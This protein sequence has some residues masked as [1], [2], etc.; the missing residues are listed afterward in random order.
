MG[1]L[2]GA[3]VLAAGFVAGGMNAVVGAGTLVSFP[4][5]L[6]IGL[7]PV[8]A[9]VS[10]SLGVLPGSVA[11]AYAYRHQLRPLRAFLRR[12][13][14]PVALGSATGALLLLLLPARVFG[15]VVPVLLVLAAVLVA[16]QPRITAMV[17]ARRPANAD[18][19][20]SVPAPGPLSV[21]LLL[22]LAVY[23]GYF[24]AGLSVMFLA[25]LGV[26]L[27]GLQVSNGAKNVLTSVTGVTSAVVFVVRAPVDWPVVVLL[28][29]G[30]AVGGLVGGSYGRRLPDAPLRVAIILIAL[31]AAVVQV[32]R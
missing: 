15:A 19:D 25:V 10:S 26:L 13:V 17:A 32:L 1:P 23:G 24:G 7:E 14:L 22:L 21:A 31:T 20:G 3:A 16:L 12:A 5:L 6:A 11:G 29:V 9:N 28:A 2:Q 8:V 18:D 30:S 27:G 4:A